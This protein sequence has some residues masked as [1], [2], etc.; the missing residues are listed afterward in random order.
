M[1]ELRKTPPAW[2]PERLKMRYQL[3]I[4]T[5]AI[6]PTIRQAGLIRKKEKKRKK[7]RDLREE[8]RKLHLLHTIEIGT[9]NL[10]DIE[11]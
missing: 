11:N 1:I 6:A 10:S 7:Q 3:P 5:K 4:S 9:N 2:G 8:K